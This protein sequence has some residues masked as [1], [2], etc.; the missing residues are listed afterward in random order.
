M[1]YFTPFTGREDE[2]KRLNLRLE[3]TLNYNGGFV[4]VKGETGIG[5]TRLLDQFADGIRGRNLHILTGRVING[6]AKPFSPFTRM[7]EHLFLNIHHDRSWFLKFMSLQTAGYFSHLLPELKNQY[8]VDLPD[9]LHPVDN[10]SIIYSFQRL[11]D[12]LSKS[13]PLV[14]ILNDIQW[15]KEESV[16]LL[17]HLVKRIEDQPIL[18]VAATRCAVNNILLE[19]A[20]DEMLRERF[21]QEINLQCF[22][23]DEVENC[24]CKKFG[25][26]LSIP[27]LEWLYKI[28]KG[29]PLYVEEILKTLVRQNII[30]QSSNEG[31]WFVSEDFEDFTIPETVESVIHYRL[32][33]MSVNE[34][35]VLSSA[36]VIGE[37]FRL[38]TVQA[39]NSD[40]SEKEIKESCNKLVDSG[41]LAEHNGL[42]Q[43]AH[44]L[45]PTVLHT[46]I[47]KNRR[48]E[49]HRKLALILEEESSGEENILPHLLVDLLPEEET[50]E[51]SV[52]LS[53]AAG[54][55]VQ[56]SYN[57]SRAVAYLRTS[58][59]IA[60]RVERPIKERLRIQTELNR[61][62]WIMGRDV[63]SVEEAEILMVELIQNNLSKEA[64]TTCRML[65]HTAL[66]A[67][68]LDKAELFL[69]KG[70]SMLDVEDTFYWTL[71][72]EHCLLLRRKGLLEESLL[73]AE[74]LS[75][76]IPRKTAPEA[77]Y[78]VF[79]NMGLV[80]FLMGEVNRAGKYLEKARK[81]VEENHM[82][83]YLGDSLLN[84]G[85][86]EM[87][88]GKLDS[89]LRKFNDS[90]R[91][92]ELLNQ[93]P[94]L[95]VSFLYTGSCFMYRG[96]YRKAINFF[97]K[98]S[99]LADEINNLKLK[100]SARINKANCLCFLS[101]I[102]SAESILGKIPEEHISGNM[103]FDIRRLL[104]EF[105]LGRMEFASAEELIE[106]ALSIAERLHLETKYGIA[107]GIKSR[108]LIGKE[109]H[110]EALSWLQIARDKLSKKGEVPCMSEALVS[111]GLAAGGSTGETALIEGLEMLFAMGAFAKVREVREILKKEK[112]F[113]SAASLISER[114]GKA[115]GERLEILTFGGFSVRRPGNLDPVAKREWQSRKARELFALI[116]VQPGSQGI[117][118]EILAFHL[119]PDAAEKKAQGNLRVAL[120]HANKALGANVIIH[121]GPFLKVNRDLLSADFLEFG[122]LACQWRDYED[123][124]KA[125]SAEDRARRALGLYRGSFLPEFYSTPLL[126]KQ[127]ELEGTRRQM[128][129]SL[130]IRSMEKCEWD[131]AAES[132]RKLLISDSCS[133]KACKILMQS[134]VN[135]GDRIGA[136]RQFNRL[137]ECLKLEFDTE[138][139]S[140]I[141]DLH[142][143]ILQETGPFS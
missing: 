103:L 128:L 79:K 55:L 95:G 115:Q 138:P 130:A 51:L 81:I 96:E 38:K 54:A 102:D 129:F 76:K 85:L 124:G 57:Y 112:G 69:K 111:Y 80:F 33:N 3:D 13:R 4:L 60:Q 5:K 48:R 28:T 53:Q 123:R 104:S 114:I 21:V 84:S 18:L 139:G 7:L 22:S 105:C 110:D 108:I 26:N 43:F 127:D 100:Y 30:Y 73:E 83:L 17:K 10:L 62:S 87:T 77:L 63:S 117:T 39:L 23:M 106:D 137:R 31:S 64:A 143:Q 89:A 20:I 78:K 40:T 99:C 86:A 94:L 32:G 36:A 42:L 66:M 74:K 71:A 44:P 92:F 91:E 101:D 90:T 52:R 24:L 27:F 1:S 41:M 122:E 9:P 72:V 125:H 47:D 12:D 82:I 109:M 45:I 65:F 16:Q 50:T 135:Q 134:L 75:G 37:Q 131:K 70:I 88:M 116:L 6:E 19:E 14:L 141:M 2:L 29:N 120:A 49:L 121:D 119:W 59:N 140:V 132:A 98:A 35:S 8:P 133:E 107:A 46:E 142:Q 118:R 15:M 34:T 136:L 93:R 11:F 25:G 58:L 68:D 56:S 61:L 97:E 67:G 113:K 126:D